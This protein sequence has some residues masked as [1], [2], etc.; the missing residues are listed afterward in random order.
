MLM[1][2]AVLTAAGCSDGVLDPENEA[3]T[4]E[5]FPEGEG[6]LVRKTITGTVSEPGT[7]TL[8]MRPETRTAIQW[9][10]TLPTPEL[11]KV[12]WV[13]LD[14]VYSY[15]QSGVYMSDI[16]TVDTDHPD[17]SKID[18]SDH[19]KAKIEVLYREGDRWYNAYFKG[20]AIGDYIGRREQYNIT[21][22]NAIPR[23]QNGR[24]AD[25]H[26]SIATAYPLSLEDVYFQNMQSYIHFNFDGLA[27]DG[28]ISG[29]PVKRITLRNLV[30][31]GRAD[32]DKERMAGNLELD[33]EVENA[34]K[35]SLV[36]RSDIRDTMLTVVP[37]ED[38]GVFVKGKEY[39]VA[40]PVRFYLKGIQFDFYDASGTRLSWV[41]TPRVTM[42]YNMIYNV[43]D[44]LEWVVTLCTDLK[45][46]YDGTLVAGGKTPAEAN[47]A[48]G[49]VIELGHTGKLEPVLTPDA[50]TDKSLVWSSSD[51]SIAKP[52]Q[53]GSVDAKMVG[54]C[55]ITA[56]A[57][58][59]DNIEYS[60][61]VTVVNTA[62]LGPGAY[63]LGDYTWP[64]T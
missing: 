19:Q 13:H 64:T 46:K 5:R 56:K 62:G 54:T 2:L 6:A 27:H 31:E 44:I 48:A 22:D 34:W 60:C 9:V 38:G 17:V 55:I 51:E 1:A 41:R 30:N 20:S 28:K 26:I 12:H 32:A 18:V 59:G 50:T 8:D 49:I 47:A 45:F 23:E 3:G 29:T 4:K 61:K 10:S 39:F 7:V 40:I 36:K 57:N 15:A 21:F 33:I 35:Y 63:T 52:G 43:G 53:D 58:G 42:N 37:V 14:E 24:F 25:Y 11:M 16:L